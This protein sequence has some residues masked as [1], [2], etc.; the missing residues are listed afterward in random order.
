MKKITLITLIFSLM[1]SLSAMAQTPGTGIQAVHKVKKQETIF[2]ISKDYGITI[3]E[4]KEAN[5]EMKSPDFTLKKGMKLNIPTPK[6]K[7]QPKP[8][9]P[10]TKHINVGVMLPL[11]DI[12]GDGKRMIEYY[13]GMLMAINDLKKENYD[14]DVMAWNV[15]ENDDIRTTLLNEGAKKC[16]IIYGPLYS[17]QVPALGDF[18]KQN[19]IKMV[20]PFSISATDVQRCDHIYQVYQSPT[21]IMQETTLQYLNFFNTANT[22]IVD[23]NDQNSKKGEFTSGLRKHLDELQ[24]PYSITNLVTANDEFI[25]AFRTDMQNVVVLN[26]GAY[27]ELAVAIKKLEQIKAGNPDINISMLG[28]NEWFLY[29]KNL[30]DHMRK[31]DTYI[32]SYY[33]F[34]AENVNI[35]NLENEYETSFGS[36]MMNAIPRFA[37]TGYDQTMF[38]LR[39]MHK[40][41]HEFHG[42]PSQQDTYKAVQTPL[43]FQRI[44]DGGYQNNEFMLVRLHE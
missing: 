19:D 13:R 14:I 12:N 44:P 27:K 20:I 31:L 40:Y 17:T 6:P 18:C 24:R 7:E 38:F 28:Y 42:T 36:P 33:N 16:N 34:N 35:K 15:A 3:D 32:P 26:T 11:H 25:K 4:L 37:I 23:C 1:V 8:I 21:K 29:T 43:E 39:G 22:I 41:G 9:D 2:G 30:G 10:L 5:P